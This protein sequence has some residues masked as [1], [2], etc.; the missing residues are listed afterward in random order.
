MPDHRFFKNIGPLNLKS[1]A[2]G[3][4]AELRNAENDIQIHDVCTLESGKPGC[5]TFL[6][7]VKY[8]K[9]LSETKASA[10]II[11]ASEADNAPSHLALLVHPNPHEAYALVANMLYKDEA[12]ETYISPKASIAATAK[13]GNDV[14]IA[15]FAVV[16]ANVIIGDNARIGPNTYIGDNVEI[17][18]N[19]VIKDNCSIT[20]TKIGANTVI[21]PGARI[22]QDGFG[23]AKTSKGMM[24]VKQLGLVIIGNYV[25][26]GANTCIDRGAIENTIIGDGTKIDNQV[27]IGHNTTIGRSCVICGQ[28]GLAGS[29]KVDDFVML[30]GGVGVAGHLTIGTGSMIAAGSGI[31]SDVAPKSIMGGRPAMPIRDWHRSN[32]MIRRLIKRENKS[33]KNE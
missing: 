19:T 18:P 7:N 8:S 14:S 22:G 21:Y 5:I 26:V 31:M 4:E 25:E 12:Q 33:G 13:L 2:E 24:K 10:C 23:F 1:I 27:Q 28:V 30:G 32:A 15:D 9:Y 16:G 29:T 17:G 11:E 6:T 3:I 20:Y